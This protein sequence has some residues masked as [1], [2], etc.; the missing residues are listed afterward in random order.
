MGEATSGGCPRRVRGPRGVV[1]G[2]CRDQGGSSGVGEG[3][4][5]VLSGAGEGTMEG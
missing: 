3:T 1:L 4:M 2:E 5:G